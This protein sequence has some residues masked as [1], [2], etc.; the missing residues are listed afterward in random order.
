MTTAT[1]FRRS[2]SERNLVLIALAG[3]VTMGLVFAV[4]F[5]SQSLPVIGGGTVYHARFAEAGGLKTGNEVRIAGVKV[6]EVV[7][8]TLQG[9]VVDVA[10]RV[11]GAD[12]GDQTTAAV[13]VKSVLGRK[14][15]AVDPIGRGELDG[16]IPLERTT[17]PYD[18][19]AALSDLS[20]NL[21]EIDTAQL[22]QSFTALSTAFRDTP[23]D[24]RGML[25]GL[26]SLSRTIS[27]RDEE[28]ASL[29]ESTEDV[30][31]TLAARH[32]EFATILTRGDQLMTE[33]EQRRDAVT[34]LLAGTA[35]LG[36]QLQGLVADNEKTLKP[37]LD[38]LDQVS[39][40]LTENQ[41]NLD[42]A[43]AALGPYYRMVT[44]ALG[45]GRWIDS[46]ICGLF[47][48]GKR[49][50]LDAAVLRDCA[51]KSGGGQ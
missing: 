20:S 3:L 42:R 43:L 4:T 25:T 15:L 37:A 1:R 8:V 34:Q 40:I 47:D 46:Y 26:T 36:T 16:P 31:A 9:R 30:S 12:L 7:G 5:W 13:K 45:N 44:S 2:F 32:G 18:V 14:Y 24:V 27:T 22:E 10:F 21:D 11:K 35:R 23:E 33:L 19:N 50:V 28:L 48:A 49:P 38:R 17:T 51:P 41:E 29:L 6:G 39:R